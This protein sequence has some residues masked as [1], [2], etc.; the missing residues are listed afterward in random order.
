MVTMVSNEKYSASKKVFMSKPHCEEIQKYGTANTTHNTAY[1][2]VMRRI[3]F[4]VEK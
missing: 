3:I 4:Q 1:S 2:N